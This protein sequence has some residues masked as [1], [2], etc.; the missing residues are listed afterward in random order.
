MDYGFTSR[1]HRPRPRPR[2]RPRPR[3][4]PRPRPRP[5]PRHRPR[6]R[7]RPRPRSRTR[8]RTIFCRANKKHLSEFLLF[9]YLQ[10]TQILSRIRTLVK[11][12]FFLS[13]NLTLKLPSTRQ[14]VSFS[15]IL[16]GSI[17]FSR[18][19]EAQGNPMVL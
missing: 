1:S 17:L 13:S 18:Q 3:P 12:T 14:A 15:W 8:S 11:L 19:K 4:G 16:T 6:P 2:A 9:I 5:R 10:T 7:P